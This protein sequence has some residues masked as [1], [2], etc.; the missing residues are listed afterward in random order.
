MLLQAEKARCITQQERRR[1]PTTFAALPI[2]IDPDTA[3]QAWGQT[4]AL[5]EAQGLTLYDAAYHELALRL[6]LQT[7][8]FPTG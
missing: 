7:T 3:V 2:H 1:A 5:A 8:F 6:A 4:L